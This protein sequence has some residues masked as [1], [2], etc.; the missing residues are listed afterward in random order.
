MDK[1][2]ELINNAK[3][4][5]VLGHVNA[6]PDSIGSCFAFKHIMRRM[7]KIADVYME[8]KPEDKLKFMGSD[9]IVF[10][11]ENVGEYDLCMCIDCGD[12]GRLG[13]RKAI[14]DAAKAT[15][16]IDHHRT[17]TFFADE[18]FVDASA[19]AAGEILYKL[20]KAMDIQLDIESAKQLYIAISADTGGFKFSNVTPAT[21]R[22]AADLLEFDFDHAE[23]ARLLYDSHSLKVM[24]L[25]AEV[26]QKLRGYADGKIIVALS[27]KDM[28]K[29]YD[30]E[31]SQLPNIVEIARSVESCKIA[32][33]L[34]EKKD[35][36]RVN[37][38]S[39]GN[40]DISGIALKYGG[41]GHAKASGCTIKQVSVDEAE[42]M[43]VQDCL[44][45]L[46]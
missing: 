42:K 18:N 11:G 24:Y 26:M 12:M 13:E 5:A 7:G 19:P 23:I 43:V 46:I 20:F 17:N 40:E 45:V 41:G 1:I 35:G 16:S 14:F 38:R 30:I 22:C 33:A 15:A 36:V 32:V 4:I 28:A 9:Y 34:K 21:M 6:D 10:D 31:E 37:L 29:R 2:I 39:N 3:T 8:E 44:E 27:D 25:S